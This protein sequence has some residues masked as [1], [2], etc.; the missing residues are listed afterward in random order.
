M[1]VHE[2]VEGH[3]L[4]GVHT[5]YVWALDNVSRAGPWTEIPFI[6]DLHKVQI[7]EISPDPNVLVN[8]TSTSYEFRLTL[9]D[10]LSGVDLSTVEYRQSL[11][12]RQYSEWKMYD[13]GTGKASILEINTTL[14][15]VPGIK[16]LVQFRARDMAKNI[17]SESR[18]FQVNSF[19]DLAVPSAWPLTPLA[20]SQAKKD[21]TLTWKG[22]YYDMDRLTYQV[23]V[24]GPKGNEMVKEVS[25]T[26]YTFRVKAPGEYRWFI[27]LRDRTGNISELVGPFELSTPSI[28]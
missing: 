1:N 24:I 14:E 3:I 9:S 6:I 2:S 28:P 5:L 27:A 23:H 21:V 8:T 26:S 12:N 16:N 7:Q 19:P 22:A 10:E 17:I 20:K 18:V 25:G 11:P 13:A 15:L 4:E